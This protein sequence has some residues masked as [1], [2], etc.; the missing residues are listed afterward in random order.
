MLPC[1]YAHGRQGDGCSTGTHW[2]M[3]ASPSHPWGTT[4]FQGEQA[5]EK[6]WEED[7]A[8]N[9]IHHREEITML[10]CRSLFY[11]SFFL[12]NTHCIDS[13]SNVFHRF[14]QLATGI[15]SDLKHDHVHNFTE[16]ANQPVLVWAPLT[17]TH[18]SCFFFFREWGGALSQ[19]LPQ[20][21]TFHFSFWW[22][23]HLCQ[24][25]LIN[26]KF[27]SCLKLS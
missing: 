26:L 2:L 24:V 25:A 1:I 10:Q 14:W 16:A 20:M 9:A 19:N 8:G 22:H 12:F 5:K 6:P 15:C 3:P 13:V 21:C 17:D 23:G 11:R 7:S 4:C 18:V 27:L